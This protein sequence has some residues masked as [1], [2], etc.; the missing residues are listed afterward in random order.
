MAAELKTVHV[1]VTGT[2][3]GVGFRF[4]TR[5][6]AAGLGLR[7]L[8]RNM[9]NGDVEIE[10]EGNKEMLDEL[11]SALRSGDMTDYITDLRIDWLPYRNKYRDFGIDI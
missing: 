5:R 11:I 9:D 10:A 7:G 1:I 2:V 3:Q 6:L 4:Y 8:V